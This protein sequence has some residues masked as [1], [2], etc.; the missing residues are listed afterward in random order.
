MTTDGWTLAEAFKLVAGPRWDARR[1]AQAELARLPAPSSTVRIS[2]IFGY[3]DADFYERREQAAVRAR[4][5]PVEARINA[6]WREIESDF[7][8]KMISGEW[9]SMGSR[10][11]Q[12]AMP[13]PLYGPGWN[14]LRIINLEKGIVKEPG[15]N[16]D[17]IY[18]VHISL[19][20]SFGTRQSKE[21]RKSDRRRKVEEALRAIAK[22]RDVASFSNAELANQVLAKDPSLDRSIT[23]MP[24]FVKFVERAREQLF[25]AAPRQDGHVQDVP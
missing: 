10:G 13:T 2:S 12:A 24:A 19:P 25:E 6:L 5:Q 7:R 20:P 22:E 14:Y 11:K 9:I 15:P 1:E 3:D 17:R 4:R 23:S 8:Q 18:N 16:G 21:R